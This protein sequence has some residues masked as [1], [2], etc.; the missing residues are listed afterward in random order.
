M[1]NGS[2]FTQDFVVGGELV[3]M[4]PLSYPGERRLP[5]V[6]EH[7]VLRDTGYVIAE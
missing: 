4:D 6:F 3:C 1:E 5:S 7:L 2:H